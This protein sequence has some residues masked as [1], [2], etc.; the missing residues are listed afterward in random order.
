[1]EKSNVRKCN[2]NKASADSEHTT[3]YREVKIG[4][5]LNRVTSVYLG[6]IDL[7]TALEDLAVSKALRDIEEQKKSAEFE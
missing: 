5:I 3:S 1:M 6:K 7:K 4:K 2:D